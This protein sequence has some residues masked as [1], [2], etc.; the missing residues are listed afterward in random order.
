VVSGLLLGEVKKSGVAVEFSGVQ[1]HVLTPIAC[2]KAKLYNLANLDQSDRQDE[3]H[4]RILIPCTRAFIRRLLQEAQA[5]G[6]LRPVLNSLE[7][8]LSLT[9]RRP[10]VQTVRL[11]RINLFRTVP[12]ADLER[13]GHAK[14]VNFVAKRLPIWQR[15]LER[16]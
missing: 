12:L 7:Q 3:R 5:T 11:H 10:V 8:L 16:D 6:K 2:L 9:S 1:F 4:V 14:L 13:A 15:S